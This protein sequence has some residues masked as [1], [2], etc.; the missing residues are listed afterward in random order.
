MFEYYKHIATTNIEVL[1]STQK[2][3]PSQAEP[4]TVTT[5]RVA[6]A[7]DFSDPRKAVQLAQSVSSPS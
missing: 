6:C 4:Y 3:N 2:G 1:Q 5:H 7:D